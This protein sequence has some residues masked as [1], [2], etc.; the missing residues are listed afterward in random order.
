MAGNLILLAT[1][2]SFGGSAFG[3]MMAQ[4]QQAGIFSYIIPFILIFAMVFGILS[5]INLFGRK[6][7]KAGTESRALNA[8]IALSV[9]F[10]SLQFEFVSIFF[11]EIFPRMGIALIGVLVLLIVGGIFIDPNNKGFMVGL[12]VI[13][14]I[15][16]GAVLIFSFNA[17]VFGTNFFYSSWWLSNMDWMV[18][19]LILV[20]LVLAIVFG[21]K[22][23]KSKPAVDNPLARA[24]LGK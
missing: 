16:V 4:W 9:S 7:D 24:L 5:K 14:M 13:A 11:A 20:G 8:L 10:M 18:P 12:M 6:E 19:L 3:Q 2:G 21:S 23:T 17:L 22:P 1:Y 15:A